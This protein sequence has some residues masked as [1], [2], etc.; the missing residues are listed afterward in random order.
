MEKLKSIL[1]PFISTIL[2]Y[3]YYQFTYKKYETTRNGQSLKKGITAVVS[4]KNEEYTIPFCLKSLVGFADQVVCIDNG[5]EDDTLEQMKKFK[6][7]YGDKIE[8][9]IIEM[10]NGLLGDCREAGLNATRYQW[11][12]RWDADMV[13][14]TSGPESMLQ[15]REK[16]LKNNRPRAIQ[17]PRTN[18]YG[19]WRHTSILYDVVDPGEPILMKMST[20]IQYKE[21]GRFDTIRLPFYY[22]TEKEKKRYY[23]HCAGLKSDI[24]LIHR[25]FYFNWR[26]AYNKA[27]T[28]EE[29]EKLKN[30]ESY[31]KAESF[32]Q[33]G[34]T[35][36]NSL[37]YRYQRQCVQQYTK[38][39]EAKYG[40]Y[41]VLI[42]EEMT[43]G[44]NRF[45]IVY[46]NNRPYIRIDRE[47]DEMKKYHPTKEDLEWSPEGFLKKL[48]TSEEMKKVF[49]SR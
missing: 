16:T 22:I 8:V 2:Y 11:H 3:L 5:S 35:D 34:T 9:D 45:E 40:E 30:F 26:E 23:H 6:A 37:K 36:L 49:S 39:D 42:K 18:L 27:S 28:A 46:Q 31:K 47:D 12:L 24:N 33:F 29:K 7:A 44:N 21:F 41:P 14:K 38:Y 17:L 48:L 13:C 15:L 43:R 19:D 32:K 20:K 25:Y 1:R 4:A 10:P